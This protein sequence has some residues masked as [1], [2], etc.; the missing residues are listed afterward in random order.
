MNIVVY[1]VV[2]VV[3]L[4]FDF[5]FASSIVSFTDHHQFIELGCDPS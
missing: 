1:C 2:V 5:A 3:I 4:R